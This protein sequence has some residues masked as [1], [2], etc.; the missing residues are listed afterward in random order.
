MTR[1]YPIW[2][3]ISLLQGEKN[4]HLLQKIAIVFSRRNQKPKGL[5]VEFDWWQREE[6]KGE[7]S[8]GSTINR[9]PSLIGL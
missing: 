2:F 8:V 5:P 6:K 7:S 4:V 1:S 3:K 9:D